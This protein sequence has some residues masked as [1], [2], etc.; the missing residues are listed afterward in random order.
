MQLSSFKD[1][2]MK[3]K[4]TLVYMIFAAV[5]TYLFAQVVYFNQAYSPLQ[6][7]ADARSEAKRLLRFI[8]LYHVQCNATLQMTN[9]SYWPL[10]TEKDGG[11]NPESKSR[12]I[13]YSIGYR[14]FYIDYSC[15]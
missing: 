7:L 1:P 2:I 8:T 12:K 14:I 5:F 13:A 9:N 15:T 4:K 10:C 3:K 11:I 6:V